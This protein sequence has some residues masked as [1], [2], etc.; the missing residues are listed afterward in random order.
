[1]KLLE[2]GMKVVERLLEKW[3]CRIV[4]VDVMQFVFMPEGRTIDAVFIL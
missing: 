2:H 4:T 1:M 3:P